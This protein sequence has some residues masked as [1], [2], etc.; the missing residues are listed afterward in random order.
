M[1]LIVGICGASGAMLGLKFLSKIWDRDDLEIFLVVSNGAKKTMLFEHNIDFDNFNT[2]LLQDLHKSKIKILDDL[3][4]GECISSG[5][6]GIDA[7]AIIPCS[8]NTLA[9]IACGI[10]DSL[11]TRSAL[12]CLKERK[13]LLLAPREMPLDSISLNN[14][15]ILSKEGVVIAPPI[16]GYY[17]NISSLESME[18]FLIGKWLDILNIKNSIYKRWG[19]S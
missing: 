19:N 1:K 11:I 9:K 10:S 12:V 3:N 18:D 15:L 6:F 7:M 5:S 2:P 16:I 13:K 14:M 4:L 8:M 17:S